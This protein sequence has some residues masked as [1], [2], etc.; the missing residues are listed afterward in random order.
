MLT[1]RVPAGEFYTESTGTFIQ[2]PEQKIQ[3]EHSLI[4]VSKWESK[5]H[6]PFFDGKDKTRDETIDYYRCMAVTQNVNPLTWINLS[7]ENEDTIMKYILDPMTGT[8]FNER[9]KHGRG[10]RQVISSE[11]IYWQMIEAGIPFECERWHIN[12][13]FTL[14]HVC[15]VKSE[16]G[17]K[18]SRKDLVSQ[19]KMLNAARKGRMGTTG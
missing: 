8:T 13:L 14:I 3:M 2:L 5:W 12:R 17:K 11:V 7:K 19:N 10:G 4:S 1:I 18:M 15:H 16:G 6:K 9:N